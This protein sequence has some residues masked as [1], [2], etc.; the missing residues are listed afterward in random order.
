[1]CE[2]NQLSVQAEALRQ[3][4]PLAFGPPLLAHI[5]HRSHHQQR[6]AQPYGAQ[7]DVH[8]ELA[9][10][11]A[12]PEEFELRAHRARGRCHNIAF[13]VGGVKGAQALGE[14]YLQGL[15]KQDLEAIAKEGSRLGIGQ[16]EGPG[17][18]DHDQRV[19]RQLQH[20]GQPRPR[21]VAGR[22]ERSRKTRLFSVLFTHRCFLLKEA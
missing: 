2:L 12:P 3:T 8:R 1:V 22:R 20:I 17:L 16:Y 9:A 15:P 6:L 21:H 7:T 18:V 19:G 11:L 4:R 10:I 14:Q 5:A 13:P